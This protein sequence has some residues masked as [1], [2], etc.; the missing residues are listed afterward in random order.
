[1]E[2]LGKG[3][4]RTLAC[5]QRGAG[6]CRVCSIHPT[7][8]VERGALALERADVNEGRC[9]QNLPGILKHLEGFQPLCIQPAAR[10]TGA[11]GVRRTHK[12]YRGKFPSSG[13]SS[14]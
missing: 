8:P 14:F 4:G 12:A 13:V 11:F 10:N 3:G 9:P 7:C 6:F 1:M 2:R 5:V